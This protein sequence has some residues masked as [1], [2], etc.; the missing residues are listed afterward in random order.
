MRIR[1]RESADLHGFFFMLCFFC[2]SQIE[3][4]LFSC[5]VLASTS[6]SLTT[7]SFK[8][9]KTAE[10]LQQFSLFSIFS[11]LYSLEITR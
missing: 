1:L 3:Q 5:I 10:S 11:I 4:I 9:K 6:L 7:V 8:H 2:F